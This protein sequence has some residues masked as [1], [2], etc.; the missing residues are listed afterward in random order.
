MNNYS[1][2]EMLFELSHYTWQ[3]EMMAFQEK[4]WCHQIRHG[5]SSGEQKGA[6]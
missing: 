6:Q 3:Y 1:A 2:A 5:S 4:K